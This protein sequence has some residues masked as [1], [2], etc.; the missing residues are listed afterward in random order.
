VAIGLLTLIEDNH[1]PT[2]SPNILRLEINR[3]YKDYLSVIDVPR[4][5]KT[6]TPSMTSKSDIALIRDI[7]LNY[8][9]NPRSIILAV[10]LANIDIAI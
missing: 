3:P 7:V 8:I 6:I 5:F 2:F 1:L 4:I 10:V 9:R